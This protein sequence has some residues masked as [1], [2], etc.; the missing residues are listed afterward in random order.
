MA[1]NLE[2]LFQGFHK[3]TREERL[4]RLK[5]MCHLSDDD[6]SV[7]E[8]KS[9]LDL[10]LAEHF[11]E[12][13]VG[14]FPM[15]LGIASY[16][17]IDGRDLPIPMAIEETS[18]V[19]ACSSTAKWIRGF[20]GSSITTS[21]EGRTIIG[22]VEIPNVTAT[23]EVMKSI[24]AREKELLE[25][26]NSVVPGLVARG[27]GVRHFETRRMPRLGGGEMLVLHVHMDPCDAMGANPSTRCAKP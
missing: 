3:L 20:E 7:L 10:D 17:R 25:I 12:N 1:E 9:P 18:V 15:P 2:S 26:A 13:L 19:A 16:F 6:L 5:S 22:Q 8:G 4:D 21:T 11:I 27:G 23:D 14:V 24:K